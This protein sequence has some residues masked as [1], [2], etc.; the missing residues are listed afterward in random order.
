M[1]QTEDEFGRYSLFKVIL[2]NFWGKGHPVIF[3]FGQCKC[4]TPRVGLAL[5]ER[6]VNSLA[7]VAKKTSIKTLDN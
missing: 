2:N 4:R 7:I 3:W 1:K 5:P 6:F